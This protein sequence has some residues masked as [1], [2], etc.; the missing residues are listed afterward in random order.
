[1]IVLSY[2]LSAFCGRR[3]G[4]QELRWEG[5]LPFCSFL[6][7]RGGAF[8]FSL[9]FQHMIVLLGDDKSQFFITDTGNIPQSMQWC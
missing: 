9:C 1:M 8:L 7:L 4:F 2:V 5:S 3:T 6:S